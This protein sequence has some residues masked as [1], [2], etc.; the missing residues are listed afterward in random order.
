MNSVRMARDTT[1]AHLP[2]ASITTWRPGGIH[3]QELRIR[4]T[5]EQKSGMVRIA[6]QVDNASVFEK[7]YHV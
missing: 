4:A 2:P 7:R 5:T 3:C 6:T 1:G